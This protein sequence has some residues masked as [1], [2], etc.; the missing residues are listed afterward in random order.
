MSKIK[1]WL[2][3][4]EIHDSVLGLKKKILSKMKHLEVNKLFLNLRKNVKA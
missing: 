1:E 2:Q 3:T 4:L